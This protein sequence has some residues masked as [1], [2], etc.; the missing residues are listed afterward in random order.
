[1]IF[2]PQGFQ[3]LVVAPHHLAARAG[4]RVLEEGG[5]AVEAMIAAASTIAVVYP[6]MNGL[7][8]DNFWLIHEPG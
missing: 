8:G 7:G 6:H 1:M 2:S 4:L 3:G 5:D